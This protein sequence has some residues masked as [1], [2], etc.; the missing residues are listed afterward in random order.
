MSLI[1]QARDRQRRR[2]RSLSGALVLSLAAAAVAFVLVG[3][4]SSPSPSEN[5]ES[6]QAFAKYGIS[7]ATL[8]EA[9]I[10]L[11]PKPGRWCDSGGGA[12]VSVEPRVVF[13]AS[14]PLQLRRVPCGIQHVAGIPVWPPATP[15]CTFR[16]VV[17]PRAH[18][19]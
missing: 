6:A 17:V 1:K 12:A 11:G 8:R 14:V 5:V 19:A 18:R 13:F 9:A 10:S 4:G 7:C 3:R 15:G 16:V 2:R